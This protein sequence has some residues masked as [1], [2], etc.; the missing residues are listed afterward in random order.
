MNRVTVS[1]TIRTTWNTSDYKKIVR[2][3]L[4]SQFSLS[5]VLIGNTK[6][7]TLNN[8]YR[9]KNYPANVLT[10]PLFENSGEIYINISRVKTEA[11]KFSLSP[12]NYAKF[13]LIHG[14][15]HLLGYSH[16]STMERAEKKF[17]KKYILR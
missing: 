3:V 2:G 8:T 13:L 7:Q 1:K 9:K 17:L 15:L 12:P 11:K 10:F 6:A 14:C 4:G 5:I 16:G